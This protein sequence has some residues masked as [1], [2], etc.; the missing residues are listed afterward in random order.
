MSSGKRTAETELKEV[1]HVVMAP[2]LQGPELTDAWL[3]LGSGAGK[4]PLPPGNRA[5]G[6]KKRGT[7]K[8]QKVGGHRLALTVTLGLERFSAGW[9]C[10]RSIPSAWMASRSSSRTLPLSWC[11]PRTSRRSPATRSVES[12]SMDGRPGSM[13]VKLWCV[14]LLS[15]A[16]AWRGPA[17]ACRLAAGTT[18]A[19]SWPPRSPTCQHTGGRS[20]EQS[21]CSI[22]SRGAE[23]VVL[24]GVQVGLVSE[25]GGRA[26]AR[27]LRPVELRLPGPRGLQGPRERQG[28]RVGGAL[29]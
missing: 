16:I 10:P 4:V 9:L 25:A 7:A 15:R 24:V 23:V 2:I 6:K 27:G 12:N 28:G 5:V 18:S 20:G 8:F 26:G 22:T 21:A 13:V 19:R 29:R 11:C 3:P 1:R 17:T 14:L